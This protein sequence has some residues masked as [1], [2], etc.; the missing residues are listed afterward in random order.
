MK[1]GHLY[2]F[3]SHDHALPLSLFA[4]LHFALLVIMIVASDWMIRLGFTLGQKDIEID[5]DLPNFFKAVT[6]SQ[7]DEVCQK[8]EYLKKR[9]GFE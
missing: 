7:A 1:S 8:H 9:Y 6:L 3:S 4:L 2:E 5:E